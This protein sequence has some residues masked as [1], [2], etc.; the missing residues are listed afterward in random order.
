[1]ARKDVAQVGDARVAV[2]A[3]QG[4]HGGWHVPAHHAQFAHAIRGVADDRSAT[5]CEEAQK[6]KAPAN[7][8]VNR[9]KS[10]INRSYN[11]ANLAIGDRES[12]S[13][14]RRTTRR[15][16]GVGAVGVYGAPVY[17]APVVYGAPS[18]P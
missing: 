1:V 10:G 13:A 7:R 18:I 11:V 5:G 14:H 6:N 4:E 9:G 17:G 3:L 16:Y 2:A 15:A 8:E 12:Q